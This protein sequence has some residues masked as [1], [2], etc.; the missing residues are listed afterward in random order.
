MKIDVYIYK[1][2][3]YIDKILWTILLEDKI[4]FCEPLMIV[5]AQIFFH[6]YRVYS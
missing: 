1:Y 3:S 6:I 4:E 2:N 5:Y